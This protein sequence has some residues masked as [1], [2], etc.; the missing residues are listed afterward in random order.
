[1]SRAAK[2]IQGV[3]KGAGNVVETVDET[4]GDFIAKIVVFRGGGG[5]GGTGFLEGLG[6]RIEES[7]GGC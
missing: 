2:E 6:V 5:K 3:G 7:W 4:G 1:M